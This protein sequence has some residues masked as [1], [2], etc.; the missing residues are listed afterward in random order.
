MT[1]GLVSFQKHTDW[2]CTTFAVT[3]GKW[4]PVASFRFGRATRPAL[5]F[6]IGKDDEGTWE[7]HLAAVVFDV[8][9]HLFGPWETDQ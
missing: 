7:F 2:R 6:F 8:L 3:R 1:A 4:R 5:S 9:A